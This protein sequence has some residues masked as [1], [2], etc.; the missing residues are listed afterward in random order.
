MEPQPTAHAVPPNRL[1]VPPLLDALRDWQ[2]DPES[3]ALAALVASVDEVARHLGVTVLELRASAPPLPDLVIERATDA[4]MSTL[5]L[6][7][8]DPDDPEPIGT[9]R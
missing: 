8:R 9:V 5:E 4:S 7:L 3:P 6:A 1:V 2:R